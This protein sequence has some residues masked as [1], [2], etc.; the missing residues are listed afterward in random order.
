MS[1]V[2]DSAV[3]AAFPVV[4]VLLVVVFV[5]W[6]VG[7]VRVVLAWWGWVSCLWSVVVCVVGCWWVVCWFS[8]RRCF[9]LVVGV[10]WCWLVGGVA[11]V[12]VGGVGFSLAAARGPPPVLG[13]CGV[14]VRGGLRTQ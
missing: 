3:C 8:T 13:V 11:V 10:L 2:V 6:F 9:G 4:G 1:L 7:V 12:V 5:V 14:G